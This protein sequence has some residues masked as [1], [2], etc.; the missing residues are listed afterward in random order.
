MTDPRKL[1][2]KKPTNTDLD[3][4]RK[5][6]TPE[7]SRKVKK[8]RKGQGEAMA[9][10]KTVG[11]ELLRKNLLEA[12]EKSLGIVTTACRMV[13]CSREIHYHYM[14]TDADYAE[15]YAKLSSVALDFVESRL[16]EKIKE[17]DSSC[18][19][20][21]LKTKGRVRGY[22]EK[23]EVDNSPKKIPNLSKL[24]EEELIMYASIQMKLNDGDSSITDAEIVK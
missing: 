18:I 5:N 17:K 9:K 10:T 13:G 8:G 16:F 12:L 14:K 15:Q 21:Y 6:F 24:S 11:P 19:I 3:T 2:F 7:V 23:I 1:D 20:F 4:Q 22:I